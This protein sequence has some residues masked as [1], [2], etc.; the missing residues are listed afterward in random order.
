MSLK[1]WFY[2]REGRYDDPLS[3]GDGISFLSSGTK[4]QGV[5]LSVVL[6]VENVDNC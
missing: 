1:V 4:L 5:G 3:E 6:S 2:S